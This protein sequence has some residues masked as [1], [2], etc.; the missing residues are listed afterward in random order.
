ME[1]TKEEYE[2]CLGRIHDLA[3][4]ALHTGKA[5]HKQWYLEQILGNAAKGLGLGVGGKEME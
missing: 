1:K 2:A 4:A 5:F 3:L